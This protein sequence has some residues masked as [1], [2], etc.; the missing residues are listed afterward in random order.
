MNVPVKKPGAYQLRIAV[1]DSASG[2]VGS[3]SHYIEV[4]DVKKDKLTLSSLVI[5]GNAPHEARDMLTPSRAPAPL[6]PRERRAR[7]PGGEGLV[8]MNTPRMPRLARLR[9]AGIRL[10]L[11]RPN[12]GNRKKGAALNSRSISSARAGGLRRRGFPVD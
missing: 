3:A 4:P 5:T 9:H 1:R 12:A 8:G 11:P 6:V 7:L 2:R 10:R